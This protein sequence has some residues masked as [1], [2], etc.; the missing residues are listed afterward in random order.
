MKTASGKGLLFSA[1]LGVAVWIPLFVVE[2]LR[3]HPG[4]LWS[5]WYWVGYP[6]LLFGVFF[7]GYRT[8]Q[9]LWVYGPVSLLSSYITALLL[10]PNTG[11][12]LPFEL[13]IIALFSVPAILL[14]KMGAR[15]SSE[16]KQQHR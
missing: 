9:G 1:L 4:H 2:T 5:M 3:H 11:N 16:A 7:I 14:A 6:M 13:L 8:K 12:L 10:I 15:L